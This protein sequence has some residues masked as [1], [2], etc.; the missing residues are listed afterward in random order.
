MKAEWL[1]A[2][3]PLREKNDRGLTGRGKR[4]GLTAK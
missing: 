3:E 4:T 2:P 1:T